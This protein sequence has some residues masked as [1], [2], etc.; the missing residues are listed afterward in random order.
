MT[1]RQIE[2]TI[3]LRCQNQIHR[4]SFLKAGDLI[5]HDHDKRDL[6]RGLVLASFGGPLDGCVRLLVNWRRSIKEEDLS[7][8]L[9]YHVARIANTCISRRRWK[10]VKHLYRRTA[11]LPG[12]NRLSKMVPLLIEGVFHRCNY[13]NPDHIPED[14]VIMVGFTSRRG[15]LF[16]PA[17]TEARTQIQDELDPFTNMRIIRRLILCVSVDPVRWY[18]KI[19]RRGLSVIDGNL[20]LDHIRKDEYIL[21]KQEGPVDITSWRAQIG[22]DD[23]GKPYVIRWLTRVPIQ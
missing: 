2:Y 13:T 7:I 4:I 6:K 17:R 18:R 1:R 14:R 12:W 10:R 5:F 21:A 8:P 15:R 22:F 9:P 3:A 16:F 20:V 23:E 19:Y 11:R